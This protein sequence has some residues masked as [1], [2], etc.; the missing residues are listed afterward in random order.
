MEIVMEM[1]MEMEMLLKEGD[2]NPTP[3]LVSV[4]F[5]LSSQEIRIHIATSQLA[6]L[7]YTFCTHIQ[8]SIEANYFRLFVFF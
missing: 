8:Q 5:R 1:E 2:G 3:C 4:G 7:L 6:G